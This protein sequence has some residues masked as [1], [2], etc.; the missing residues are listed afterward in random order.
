MIKSSKQKWEIGQTVKVGFV[1]GLIVQAAVPTPGDS[2]PDSY[3]LTNAAGDKVYEFVPH[4]GL[5]RIEPSQAREIIQTAQRQAAKVAARATERAR[6][7]SAAQAAIA[8]IWEDMK[9][10]HQAELAR[11]EWERA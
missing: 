3:L 2:L 7:T 6:Q 5:R 9:I 1:S 4:N 10:G 8:R 11:A